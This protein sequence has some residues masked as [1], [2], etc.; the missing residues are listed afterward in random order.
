ML[1]ERHVLLQEQLAAGQSSVFGNG[2]AFC[3]PARLSVVRTR[4]EGASSHVQHSIL[5]HASAAR[6]HAEP[7]P[8]LCQAGSPSLPNGSCS[9]PR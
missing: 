9:G 2:N 6:T 3:S 5:G 8:E 1:G 4:A 7:G